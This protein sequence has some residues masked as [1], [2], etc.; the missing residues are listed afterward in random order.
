LFVFYTKISDVYAISGV[1]AESSQAMHLHY[2]YAHIFNNIS[3]A[4]F[5]SCL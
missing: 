5:R 2:D 4:T 3:H 1:L